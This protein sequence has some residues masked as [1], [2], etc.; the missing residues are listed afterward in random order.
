VDQRLEQLALADQE[1]AR[2][3]GQPR[4][5]DVPPVSPE[6]HRMADGRLP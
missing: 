4:P 1:V 5:W 6:R 3:L 2:R